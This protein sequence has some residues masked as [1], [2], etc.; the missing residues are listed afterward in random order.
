MLVRSGLRGF[1]ELTE[2]RKRL[3]YVVLSKVVRVLENCR[4][5]CRAL[6]YVV[7]NLEAV[8]VCKMVFWS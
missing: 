2:V 1:Q 4:E 7:E 5:L 6:R 3:F 8:E